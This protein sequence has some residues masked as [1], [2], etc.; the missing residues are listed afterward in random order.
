MRRE[1]QALEHRRELVCLLQG[2]AGSRQAGGQ[3]LQ[4]L[5]DFQNLGEFPFRE[6]SDIDASVGDPLYNPLL[7]Q[8]F[9]GIPDR[10][11]THAHLPGEAIDR[12]AMARQ[13]P[14]A[15]DEASDLS[16]DLVIEVSTFD[17]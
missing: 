1:V 2:N 10:G 3:T 9:Q 7:S 14:S 13:Q 17:D 15:L 16:V 5:P 8:A 11:P 4:G 12:D 6:T